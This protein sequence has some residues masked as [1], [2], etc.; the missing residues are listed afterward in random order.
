MAL[1]VMVCRVAKHPTIL[2]FLTALLAWPAW[3]GW[4]TG[5]GLELTKDLSDRS[6]DLPATNMGTGILVRSPNRLRWGDKFALRGDFSLGMSW[7]QDRVEWRAYEATVPVYSDDHR[8]TLTTMGLMFGP[9]IS[10][11]P[12]AKL[13]PYLGSE[14]GIIWARHW[15]RFDGQDERLLGLA[16]GGEGIHP[17]TTQ[18]E[19]AVDLH[20][21]A[22]VELPGRL[23]MEVEAGYN[24]A[25]M[26][27][28]RLAKAPDALE[29]VRIAY[30]LNQ[31]RIGVNLVIPLGTGTES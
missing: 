7:G 21:G 6:I 25:L 23:A 14:M 16:G 29:A 9:E 2:P 30:G 19:T 15:H 27:E 3:A 26:R 20:G 13:S 24:V 17:Y 18:T 10:P 11:W 12:E 22:R 31:L 8:T 1:P 4:E 28:A 5:V